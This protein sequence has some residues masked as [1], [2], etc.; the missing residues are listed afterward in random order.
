MIDKS[1]IINWLNKGGFPF[2]MDCL[3][4]FQSNNFKCVPCPH[5]KDD[6]T[7]QYREVD[8]MAYKEVYHSSYDYSFN[9]TLVVEC[10]SNIEPI[11]AMGVD[12]NFKGSAVINNLICSK[13]GIPLRTKLGKAENNTFTFGRMENESIVT[14]ALQYRGGTMGKQNVN[15]NANSKDRVFESLSQSYGACNYFRNSSNSVDLNFTNIYIPVVIFD[16]DIYQVSSENL[17]LDI[18]QKEFCKLSKLL[19]F[20]KQNPLIYFHLVSKSGLAKYIKQVGQEIDDFLQENNHEILLIGKN[21]PNNTGHGK[22][23]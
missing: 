3:R 9:I 10:K 6:N 13:N 2:E 8:F 15:K 5:Y 4:A 23:R 7:G 16:N 17:E 18:L 11:I 21:N 12:N 1:E 14:N 22:Y 19:S 20:D